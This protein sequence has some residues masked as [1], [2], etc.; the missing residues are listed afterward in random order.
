VQYGSIL[1]LKQQN[2]NMYRTAS[3]CI[4]QLETNLRLLLSSAFSSP[5]HYFSSTKTK[6]PGE[7]RLV[8]LDLVILEYSCLHDLIIQNC[9]KK[10][11]IC[12]VSIWSYF[13]YS[14]ILLF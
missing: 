1:L 14:M 5:A 9:F 8:Y 10:R 13:T 2:Y 11:K 6:Y 4:W 7:A 12:S 3:L